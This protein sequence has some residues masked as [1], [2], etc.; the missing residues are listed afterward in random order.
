MGCTAPLP[1]SSP[2]AWG[3]FQGFEEYTNLLQVFPT[4]VGVFLALHDG[5][6][7]PERLPH[8][9]G[10]VSGCYWKDGRTMRS[11][12]HAWG[13]FRHVGAALGREAVFPTRVGVFPSVTVMVIGPPSLPHTRGGVSAPMPLFALM[14]KS[15][16][17][18]W[19]CFRATAGGCWRAAVFPTRVGVFL[20]PGSQTS[21]RNRLPHTRGG[22]SVCACCTIV[23]EWSSPHAW[24]CFREA[25]E[26]PRFNR[27]FPTRVG[28][29]L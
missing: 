9:R 6:I 13:C 11:S 23:R 27:V 19:G 12:P 3:C 5:F 18:A 15:S 25:I 16:P 26:R 10:G 7:S 29:F 14:S 17:H 2:H 24:G 8:T 28:V 4:R 22:V 21:A 20:L 1:A